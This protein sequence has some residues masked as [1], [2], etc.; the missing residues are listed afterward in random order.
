MGPHR[1]RSQEVAITTHALLDN[2]LAPDQAD[3]DEVGFSM[4]R[5]EPKLQINQFSDPQSL[6]IFKVTRN[7]SFNPQLN[8]A[9]R[10]EL[11][12]SAQA[13]QQQIRDF[14]NHKICG[15]C[16]APPDYVTEDDLD[17]KCSSA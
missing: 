13:K 16:S 14:R 5:P 15:V 4:P 17:E 11:L 3:P 10:D 6:W 9:V 1:G 7:R 12:C 8:D 2:R